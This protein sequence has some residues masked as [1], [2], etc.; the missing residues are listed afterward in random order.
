MYAKTSV[1]GLSVGAGGLA[2]TGFGVSWYVVIASIL[3]AA[4]L[5]FLRLGRRRAAR[6]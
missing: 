3:L 4:G 6:R 1:L 2:F 5:L